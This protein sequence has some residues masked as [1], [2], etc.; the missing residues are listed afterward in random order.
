ME[1]KILWKTLNGKK[2][3]LSRFLAWRGLGWRDAY[4]ASNTTV[5]Q[6]HFFVQ[7]DVRGQIPSST[8]TVH[9]SLAGIVHVLFD[10]DGAI[11]AGDDNRHHTQEL[12][13]R[14]QLRI[15]RPH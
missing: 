3:C 5:Y 12:C 8:V 6:P 10:G 7:I 15:L 14:T 4:T 13:Q 2:L 1:K 11:T 9:A